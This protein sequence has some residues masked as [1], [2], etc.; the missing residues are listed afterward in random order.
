[1]KQSLFLVAAPALTMLVAHNARAQPVHH[2][3]GLADVPIYTWSSVGTSAGAT[4]WGEPTGQRGALG[5][6]TAFQPLRLSLTS[7]IFPVAGA[8]PQCATLQDDVGNSSHGMPVQ[9]FVFMPLM[10]RLTLTLFSSD[11]CPIDGGGGAGLTYTIPLQRSMWLVGSAGVYGVPGR[12]PV[13]P[14]RTASDLRLDLVKETS[15]GHTLH[16]GIERKDGT[17]VRGVPGMVTFGGGF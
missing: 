6:L 17:G 14:A 16:F 3:P 2:A 9:R 11:G 12:G 10:P 7:T 5:P 15:P 4:G 8:Y 1:M 13:L